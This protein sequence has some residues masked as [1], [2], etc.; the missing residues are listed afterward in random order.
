MVTLTPAED[1]EFA[2]FRPE[3]KVEA[4]ELGLATP[5]VNVEA[6]DRLPGFQSSWSR[7]RY[8]KSK[9]GTQ[10]IQSLGA[11]TNRAAGWRVSA[12]RWVRRM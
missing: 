6:A 7:A 9:V 3:I 12:P 11:V 10:Q 8:N 2:G 5:A 1:E 4:A